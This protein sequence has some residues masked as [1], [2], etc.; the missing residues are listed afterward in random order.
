MAEDRPQR[1]PAA[2]DAIA[3]MRATR[4]SVLIA[5]GFGTLVAGVVLLM[6][7]LAIAPSVAPEHIVDRPV[8]TMPAAST[9]S[10][11]SAP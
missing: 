8:T 6:L 1:P 2:L 10:T 7:M 3:A 4:R 11:V 5:R 9:T